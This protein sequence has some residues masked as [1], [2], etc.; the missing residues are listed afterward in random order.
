MKKF[1]VLIYPLGDSIFNLPE[2]KQQKHIQKVGIYLEQLK[3]NDTLV[4]AQ[5]LQPRGKFLL[6]STNALSVETINEKSENIAG[7]YLLKAENEE[8]LIAILRKDPRFE[9]ATWKLEI[10]EIMDMM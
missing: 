3:H 9:D 7:Y 8:G 4:D 1:M 2:Q 10:R 6:G 5:P